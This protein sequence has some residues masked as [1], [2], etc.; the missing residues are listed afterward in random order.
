[1]IVLDNIDAKD[2]EISKLRKELNLLK[3]DKLGIKNSATKLA[4]PNSSNSALSAL[5]PITSNFPSSYTDVD[6]IETESVIPSR[7][8][9][10]N[11]S[12]T[13]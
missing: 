4:S 6:G 9:S 13:R 1:M 10:T 8:T 3:I 12:S 5:S 2:R 11:S 7:P